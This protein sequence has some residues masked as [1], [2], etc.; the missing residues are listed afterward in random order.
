IIGDIGQKMLNSN[1]A[2][3]KYA[4]AVTV[5]LGL[6]VSF[7]LAIALISLALPILRRTSHPVI[8][9]QQLSLTDALLPLILFSLLCNIF[10]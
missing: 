4:N 10:G 6:L 5:A 1:N 8:P 3:R 9:G 2:A 7:F